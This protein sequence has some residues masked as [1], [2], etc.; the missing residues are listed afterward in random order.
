[1]TTT[2]EV[3]YAVSFRGTGRGFAV[4]ARKLT[5]QGPQVTIAAEPF[6]TREAAQAE[7]DRLAKAAR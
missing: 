1:M 2:Q 3:T 6:T 4:L 7:A 5:P